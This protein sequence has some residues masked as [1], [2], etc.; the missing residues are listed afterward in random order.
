MGLFHLILSFLFSED[1]FN[2]S[3]GYSL[4]HVTNC[5]SSQRW[6]VS[7]GLANKWFL[8]LH[9][10]QS[11]VSILDAERVLLCHGS[12]SFLNLCFQLNEFAGNVRSMAVDYWSIS[13]FYWSWMI[14]NDYLGNERID[15]FWWILERIS[16]NIPSFDLVG[17]YFYVETNIVAWLS[18]LDLL[19][20]HLNWFYLRFNVVRSESYVHFLLKD[21]RLNSSNRNCS[22]ALN[23]INIV[24]WHSQWLLGWSFWGLHIVQNL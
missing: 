20:V 23:F 22:K 3:H 12:S 19:M 11:W 10:H 16:C 21:T 4:L 2:Y 14:N 1:F 8:G 9:Q 7:E 13:F 17:L 18:L 6:I 24:N 5:K 15:F